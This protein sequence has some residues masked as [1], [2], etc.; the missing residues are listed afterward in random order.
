MAA[1]AASCLM[2]REER[3]IPIRAVDLFARIKQR[4]KKNGARH[5]GLRSIS[6]RQACITNLRPLR[7]SLGLI[8]V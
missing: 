2:Q 8:L 1:Q 4:Q 5:Q 6:N 7:L 3:P